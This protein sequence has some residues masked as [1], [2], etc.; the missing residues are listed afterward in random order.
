MPSAMALV[1]H[2]SQPIHRPDDPGS[3]AGNDRLAGPGVDREVNGAFD[4]PP[5]LARLFAYHLKLKAPAPARRS[6][7]NRA[8][9]IVGIYF[10]I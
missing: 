6:N 5:A 1:V 10:H 7:G 4:G 9:A 2:S 8:I 3:R